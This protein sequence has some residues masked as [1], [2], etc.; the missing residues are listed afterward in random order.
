MGM[1]NCVE[2]T[3]ESGEGLGGQGQRGE[4]WDNCNNKNKKLKKK[5][6]QYNITATATNYHWEF[7]QMT[8]WIIKYW[9]KSK[10]KD[11]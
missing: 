5:Y 6:G 10:T 2:I 8:K 1:D 7:V 11:I 9:G 3:W 4:N